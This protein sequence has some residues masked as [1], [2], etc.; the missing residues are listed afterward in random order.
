MYLLSVDFFAGVQSINNKMIKQKLIAVINLIRVFCVRFKFKQLKVIIFI[1][2]YN[3]GF[4]N[5]KAAVSNLFV[6]FLG[7]L[8]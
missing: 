6:G 8:A 3:N 7:L 2:G 1:R 4:A 5:K